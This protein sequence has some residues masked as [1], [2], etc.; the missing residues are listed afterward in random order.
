[1]R[2]PLFSKTKYFILDMDGTFYLG[3]RM[4]PGADVFVRALGNFGLDYRFF[5]N[6]SSHAAL[7]CREK[8]AG[9]GFPVEEDRVL[10]STHVAA[11][12]LQILHP[13]A[14]VFALG[15]EN[16]HAELHAAGIRL[17]NDRPDILLLGFDTTLSYEKITR[18][19]NWI[20][21]GVPYFATHPDVNCP[22][23]GGFLPD[24]GS[25]IALFSA[26]AGRT[27]VILGKPMRSTVDFL[28]RKL[29]CAPEA[30]A[31][32]GD[33]LE[34]DIAIGVTH[35]IPAVL[36]LTGV[37]TRESHTVSSIKADLVVEDLAALGQYLS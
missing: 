24:T 12:F 21:Q 20:A 10:L 19:A 5:S 13:G 37:A 30:L 11:D 28:C 1:M 14:G 26:S 18:A 3:G 35:G 29:R 7:S 17:V 4:L 8:L 23:D 36:V 15:N 9:M 25:M 33:R 31:F 27:P 16:M 6:N 32:V 22:A 2:H 34:T